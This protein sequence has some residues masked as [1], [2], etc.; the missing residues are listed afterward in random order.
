MLSKAS[1]QGN[2]G[3]L[4]KG[5]DESEEKLPIVRGQP[6]SGSNCVEPVFWCGGQSRTNIFVALPSLALLVE[7][8]C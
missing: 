2:A 4:A 1:P 8:G 6:H 7:L 5:K 3:P